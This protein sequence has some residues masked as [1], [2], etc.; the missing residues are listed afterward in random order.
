MVERLDRTELNRPFTD[1]GIEAAQGPVV[2]LITKILD[3]LRGDVP[4]DPEVAALDIAHRLSIARI[5]PAASVAMVGF[6]KHGVFASKLIGDP[7]PIFFTIHWVA[8]SLG[9]M[10]GREGQME[11]WMLKALQSSSSLLMREGSSNEKE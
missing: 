8:L 3:I 7:G 6:V 4:E 2:Q 10:M 9:G 5:D 11:E 1:S